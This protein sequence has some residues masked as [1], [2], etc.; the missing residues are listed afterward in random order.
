MVSSDRCYA[1]V[2]FNNYKAYCR[3]LRMDNPRNP[4]I[5]HGLPILI[6]LSPADMPEVKEILKRTVGLFPVN[7]TKYVKVIRLF[8]RVFADDGSRRTKRKPRKSKRITIQKTEIV[9]DPSPLAGPS[10]KGAL[11]KPR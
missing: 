1:S 4:P 3:A 5:L 10:N 8:V 2:V 9:E 11:P 7:G 6:K